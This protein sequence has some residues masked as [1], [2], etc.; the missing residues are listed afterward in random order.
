MRSNITKTYAGRSEITV[1]PRFKNR[2]L[3]SMIAAEDTRGRGLETLVV[4]QLANKL[5]VS[6]DSKAE[7]NSQEA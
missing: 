3:T 6:W 4:A 1:E 7:L 5:L 2:R